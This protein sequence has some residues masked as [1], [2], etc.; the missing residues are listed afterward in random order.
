MTNDYIPKQEF[1]RKYD[2]FIGHRKLDSHVS[3]SGTGRAGDV[4]RTRGQSS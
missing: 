2:V 1:K 4:Q 3:D